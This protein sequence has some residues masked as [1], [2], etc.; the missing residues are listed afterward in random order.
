MSVKKILNADTS[1][2]VEEMLSGFLS[3]YRKYY[4]KVGEYNAIKVPQGQSSPRDRRR[5]RP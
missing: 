3:A 2:V 4:K 1:N 5:Q